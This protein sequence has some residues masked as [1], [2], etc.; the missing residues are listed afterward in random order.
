MNDALT[1]KASFLCFGL[2]CPYCDALRLRTMSHMPALLCFR[3]SLSLSFVRLDS[4][5]SC[6]GSRLWNSN[7]LSACMRAVIIFLVSQ[8]ATGLVFCCFLEGQTYRSLCLTLT[9]S[10]TQSSAM[11]LVSPLVWSR[12]ND[13]D[14]QSSNSQSE[15]RGVC[16]IDSDQPYVRSIFLHDI[17]E[18]SLNALL[19]GSKSA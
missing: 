12:W 3:W 8:R 9:P 6:L 5:L 14:Q 16:P 2:S 4:S 17:G 19:D 7:V 18:E 15:Q 10:N 11:F 1:V 13:S